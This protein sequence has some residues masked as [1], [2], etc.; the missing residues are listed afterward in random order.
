MPE[1]LQKLKSGLSSSSENDESPGTTSSRNDAQGAAA[2]GT[3]TDFI[4]AKDDVSGLR[5]QSAAAQ[6]DRQTLRE[7]AEAEDAGAGVGANSGSD[8]TSTGGVASMA[9]PSGGVIRSEEA[10]ARDRAQSDRMLLR[11]AA[12]HDR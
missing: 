6:S 9:R 5:G 3:D 2:P 1:I 11:K 12:A 4:P 8:K 10:H 7:A